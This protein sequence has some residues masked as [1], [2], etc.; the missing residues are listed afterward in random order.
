MAYSPPS[1]NAAA[2][3][4]RGGGYVSP[5]WDNVPLPFGELSGGGA[6]VQVQ[7]FDGA[8]HKVVPVPPWRGLGPVF[9]A[10]WRQAPA[11]S[12]ARRI[13]STQAPGRY[14]SLDLLWKPGSSLRASTQI[15]WGN[16]PAVQREVAIAH[17]D[18][19]ERPWS[20]LDVPWGSPPPVAAEYSVN[21][22]MGNR[23]QIPRL[24]PWTCPP[25]VQVEL[26]SAWELA[27]PESRTWSAPW[28]H[29]RLQQRSWRVSWDQAP[30]VPHAYVIKPPYVPPP[31]PIE[32]CYNP[33]LWNATRMQFRGRSYTPPTS[34]AVPLP[35]RCRADN[36]FL[37]ARSLAVENTMTVVRLPG[38]EP[39]NVGAVSLSADL[40]SF[41]W[42]ISLRILDR[43]S[44]T[45]VLPDPDDGPQSV[46][47]AI[48]GHVW[49]GLVERYQD[50]R[51][52]GDTQFSATGRSRTALL[53]GPYEA[54]RAYISTEAANAQQLALREL[55]FSGFSLDWQ[56]VDWLVPAGAF[57]YDNLT[58][59]DAVAQIA[60]AIGA[61]VQAHP[62]ED[63][64]KVISR[65]PTSPWEW[66]GPG[67]E[68]AA[69][70]DAG[71]V[72][73]IGLDWQ[74][75]PAFNGV[76]VSGRDQGVLVQVIRDGTPGTPYAALVVDPLIVASAAGQERG[77]VV[78][79]QSEDAQ[80]IT[81]V[82]PLLAD[83]EPPGL[84]QPGALLEVQDPVWG[85]Y[86]AQ[87]MGVAIESGRASIDEP[88][89]VRQ[90]LTIQ[91]QF[92][93]AS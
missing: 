49:T 45:L 54:P 30:F 22:E 10:R 75:G 59:L 42:S 43:P 57:S 50:S 78:I 61:V 8:L 20:E 55:E 58:P 52:H 21:Y 69:I 67:V 33:P 87:V 15:R 35:F 93:R 83:P 1:W 88:L 48:N 63:S 68:T 38:R 13:T 26:E 92:R 64:I 11:R 51:K 37:I 82:M 90:R 9:G 53:A 7:T 71:S 6:F 80:A 62:S 12:A 85:T 47:I 16:A 34:T 56:A 46:E 76:Y 17:E 72:V 25:T 18:S 14:S 65:Y 84:L 36:F 2:L 44:L 27:A 70:I 89:V 79:A 4:F 24:A 74:P 23:V 3:S 86:R 91:R 66:D 19:T 39:L 5:T 29:A 31:I 73:S 41:A 60:S 28:E 32:R 40:D 81:L 77:R